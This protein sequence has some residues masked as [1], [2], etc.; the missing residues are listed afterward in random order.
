MTGHEVAGYLDRVLQQHGPIALPYQTDVRWAMRE[1]LVE[2]QKVFP[3]LGIH[4]D[5]YC[6]TDGRCMNYLKAQGTIPVHYQ[7]AKY[8][9]PVVIWLEEHYPRCAPLVYVRPTP[10]MVIKHGHTY[11]DNSGQVAIPLLQNWTY[12]QNNTLVDVVLQ[13]SQV[14]GAE[15]PLYSR[16]PGPPPPPSAGV[17]KPPPN[18]P[19]FSGIGNGGGTA[20]PPAYGDSAASFSMASPPSHGSHSSFPGA[21]PAFPSIP[22]AS[23]WNSNPMASPS[24]ALG[25]G[26][27]SG[28]TANAS[29]PPPPPPPPPIPLPAGR[30]R[31]ILRSDASR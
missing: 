21:S 20:Q 27:S 30:S 22:T 10:N 31:T 8:N 14:F 17:V 19:G 1:Q 9:I 3:T 26:V 2:L 11:V 4:V 15:P 16:Q 29:R 23:D 24:S 7:G 12:S 28:T 5:E 18:Y 25:L 13:M 6:T